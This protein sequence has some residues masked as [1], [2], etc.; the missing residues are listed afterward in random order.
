MLSETDSPI[1]G[2]SAACGFEDQ[3][4]FSKVFKS[5]TGISPYDYRKFG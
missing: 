3:S 2:I 1:N 4:W 5:Y